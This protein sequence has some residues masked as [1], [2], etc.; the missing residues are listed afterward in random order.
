MGQLRLMGCGL[1]ALALWAI[2]PARAQV[3]TPDTNFL[4]GAE[5]AE[6]AA[7]PVIT[8]Q[9]FDELPRSKPQR[10]RVDPDKVTGFD[11]GAFQLKPSLG[12][13]TVITNNVN[14][15]P[16]NRKADIGLELKPSLAFQSEWPRH[17]WRGTVNA[18]WLHY[19]ANPSADT[20]TGAAET[21]FR[22][23]IRHTTYAD[24]TANANVTSTS[25]G[26]A[27]VPNAAVGRR[28][29]WNLGTSA[30]INHDFGPMQGQL[31]LG[32]IRQAYGNVALSGGG[33]ENNADRAYVEPSLSLRDT[34]GSPA[35]RLKPYVE[36]T[37][38]PRV[39]DQTIDRN[40]QK[41]NSQGVGA[42]LGVTLQDGPIWTGDFSANFI[43]R[44]YD[45]PA[46]KTAMAVGLNGSLTWS[47]TPLWNVVASSGVGLTESELAGV[48]ATPSW[49]V[50]LNASYAV[51]DNIT[52]RAGATAILTNNGSTG[53][54][55]TW[56]AATGAEWQLN[57]YLS[58][59]GTLQSTWF[60]AAAASSSYDEQ[61]ATVAVVVKP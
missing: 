3:A 16:A 11:D 28:Q 51:R 7:P 19:L 45:D 43:A 33:I 46:L 61:R 13:G 37:Y 56:Q 59:S 18:E 2:G 12:I 44:S 17:N 53:L 6:I 40:G 30:A 52:L 50:G 38:D 57:P 35:A 32:V 9:L 41:R 54:D 21:T 20:L 5:P 10:P 24:F 1:L 49:N 58:L 34:W 47:P 29:D 27:E 8:P 14:L 25:A 55:T 22:L 60:N 39:H 48:S 42:A 15:S 23:D 31:K 26:V 4:Y 36:L